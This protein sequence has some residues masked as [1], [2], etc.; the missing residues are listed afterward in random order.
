MPLLVLLAAHV[1]IAVIIGTLA[2][3][4]LV[5]LSILVYGGAPPA[6]WVGIGAAF[7]LVTVA[8]ASVGVLLGVL[9]PTVRAA[10]GVGVL[11]FFLFMNLGGAGPPPQ[12]LP[13]AMVTVGRLVPVTPASDLLRGLWLGLG[14]KPTAAIA[15]ATIV[16][17]SL[18]IGAWRLRQE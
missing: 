5:G 17:F 13:D 15:M 16:V 1:L 3:G 18:L 10:Q 12:L 14:W 6:G 9:L 2:A 7:L 4:L 8:F 11:L